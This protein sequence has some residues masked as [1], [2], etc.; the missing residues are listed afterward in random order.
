MPVDIK[1]G[2]IRSWKYA[3]ELQEGES[4]KDATKQWM[5]I[6]EGTFVA[7]AADGVVPCRITY[8]KKEKNCVYLTVDARP[9]LPKTDDRPD[10]NGFLN[11]V[12]QIVPASTIVDCTLSID[13]GNTRTVALLVDHVGETSGNNGRLPVYHLPMHWNWCPASDQNGTFESVV[14]FICP[15]S[16]HDEFCGNQSR[17]SFVKLGKFAIYNNK[18]F[19]RVPQA[20]LYT[21]S[22][23]KRYFWDKDA[24]RRDWIG[25]R[26]I[27]DSIAKKDPVVM[28]LQARM[29]AHLANEAKSEQ[30]RLPPA[31]ILSAMVAEIYEQACFYVGSNEFKQLTNDD[32]CRRI[33]K[34][35]VTYPSTLLPRELEEYQ[36]Q[37]N[38]GLTAYLHDYPKA[39]NVTL[40]SEIDEASSV[41]AVYAYSEMRKSNA[42]FWLQSIGRKSP[43]GYQARIA[44]IDV[45]GGTTDLSVSSVEAIEAEAGIDPFKASID[46]VFRDG[47][48]NAGDALMF[49]FIR[50][51]I[52]KLGFESILTASQAGEGVLSKAKLKASYLSPENEAPVRYLTR[53]FWFDLAIK[54][55]GECDKLLIRYPGGEVDESNFKNLTTEFELDEDA[56]KIWAKL[57]NGVEVPEKMKVKITREVFDRY[58]EAAER[59]F[60]SVA[61]SF[62]TS[63]YA[64]DVDLLLFSGKTA[65]FM[66]VQNV[67]RK[68]VALPSSSIRSMKN[69][70]VGTWCGH[71]TD[72]NG[73]IADSKI[74]TALGGAL[75]SL[76]TDSS[77]NMSF[78]DHVSDLACKWGFVP[79]NG[80]IAFTRPIFDEGELHK[81]IP[82]NGYRKLI[83][84]QM[85]FSRTAILSY[86]LRFKPGV[87]E[88]HHGLNGNRASIR[89]LCDP[90][91]QKLSIEKCSGT[92]ADY[93]EVKMDDVE[94]RVCSMSG[95]FMMDKVVELDKVVESE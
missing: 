81:D 69:F 8:D 20:S 34:V 60:K 16:V 14:S 33:S 78:Q 85:P 63:I 50:T 49:E 80:P 54:V 9:S 21:L 65:E 73:R 29:A 70:Q 10:P 15:D 93:T 11:S 82:M 75:Y 53:N 40:S 88:A 61:R 2:E 55:A 39:L 95:E 26:Y 92:Y 66:A 52:A 12:F 51:C 86:E 46:L 59:T 72:A 68:Y 22:S 38:K 76:R 28:P 19:G 37:L 89:L 5:G 67:F 24:P 41:L 71:L 7:P 57:F 90:V 44:V 94:C 31:Y 17:A 84:R 58:L 62:A 30:C 36:K 77:V 64:Y 32:S 3:C 13:L 83:A 27:Q 1:V 79:D 6:K 4:E 25:A 91:K 35:H 43:L 45:G 42:L 18:A 23:P 56:Q 87:L 48:N 47:V 74:S